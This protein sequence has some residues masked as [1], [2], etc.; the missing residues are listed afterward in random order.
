MKLY[1]A[2]AV[3]LAAAPL[4]ATEDATKLFADYWAAQM[5]LS[6]LVA[7]FYGERGYDELLDD[8]GPAGRAARKASDEDLLRRARA[9]D[10]KSLKPEE[11][12]SVDVMKAMLDDELEGLSLP[13]YEM[14]VDHM[15]GGQSWIPTVIQTS[16]P[17]KDAKDAAA[18]EKRLKAMPLYFTRHRENVAAG[19]KTGR[20][21]ARVPTEKLIR[22]L[23]EMLAVPAD[24]SPY[25][26]A[27]ARLPEDLRKEWAPRLLKVVS[28]EVYPSLAALS[29]WLKSDYLPKT[30]TDNI[31]LSGV[32]GGYDMY[33][34]TIRSHTSVNKLPDQLH[35]IGLEELEGIRAEM[36]TIARHAGHAGD[37]ESFL[38]VVRKDPA[39]FFKTREEVLKDA[40]RLVTKAKEKLPEWFG[41]LPKTDL[42]V[43]P[44]EEFQEKNEAAARYFQPPTDLSRPG[45]YYI[46]TYKP[47]SRP[48]FSMTSLAVHEGLPGHHLQ[49]AL[50]LE[51]KDLP[52]FRRSAGFTSYVEGWALYTE[53]LGDEMGLYQDDL[54]RL[55]MLSDQALRASRLVVDTGLHAKSWT[56]DKAIV[57]MKANTPMSQEEIEAEV[58]RYTVWP[59]QALAYKVGQR[60]IMALREEVKT[61]TGRRF[62]IKAFHD[63]VLRHG[64]L[65]LPVLRASVL[66]AFPP[67]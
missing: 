47:E 25:A 44:V 20:I 14:E 9:V 66:E 45:V 33:R 12:L 32:P 62:D 6:P 41:T 42:V 52:Q 65:P 16:Q 54:S 8:N 30:R 50:A 46:N 2:L 40:E 38:D 24:K 21:A 39:N 37:L 26:D 19:L 59:G 64:P 51:N 13:F 57:F 27:C 55:G 53:R 28:E 23:D 5:K 34:H 4:R 11:R 10:R 1:L 15:D 22:Q 7:T 67:K 49:I 31:G 48:R 18:L 17:M 3:L 56:R 29:A 63:A 61:R 58:D 60:E 36:T 35:K 43:K